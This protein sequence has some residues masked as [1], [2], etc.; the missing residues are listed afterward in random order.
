MGMWTNKVHRT[1]FDEAEALSGSACGG[2]IKMWLSGMVLAA[3]P[4]VVGIRGIM[5]G[6]AVLPGRGRGNL[7][8]AGTA[9]IALSIAYISA[10]IFI[11]FHYFWGLHEALYRWSEIGKIVAVTAF[12]ASFG[13]AL[14][15][16]IM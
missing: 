6:H 13:Y 8:V 9:A 14:W 11:H 4:V 2:P 15:H 10:G 5:S 1:A 7:H 16:V 12:L 3:I